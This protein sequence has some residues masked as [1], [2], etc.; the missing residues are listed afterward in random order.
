MTPSPGTLKDQPQEHRVGVLV[1]D[2]QLLFREA[3]REVIEATPGF[4]LLGEAV[5]GEQAL[6]AADEL[7]PDLILLDVRMPGMGGLEAAA[8]LREAHPEQ[9][10]VL[11]SVERP[12][13]LGEQV[14]AQNATAIVPKQD[15]GAALLRSLWRLYG[16]PAQ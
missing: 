3:A 1:V 13:D 11:V 10:V 9:L 4:E 7:C 16:T 6:R 8:R 2:D 14:K 5:S 12:A 15:F